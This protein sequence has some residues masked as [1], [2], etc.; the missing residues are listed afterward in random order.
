[1]QLDR[2][3]VKQPGRWEESWIYRPVVHKR[4]NFPLL[5]RMAGYGRW[6]QGESYAR[7]R[8]T[9]FFIEYVQAGNVRLVQENKDYLIEAGEAY[10]LRK[11]V[12]HC[13]STGPAGLVLKRF[14][15]VAGS[16]LDHYLQAL[17][18]WDRDVIRLSNPRAFAQLMKQ[19][20]TTL[21][22]PAPEDDMQTKIHL[23]CLAYQLLLEL[24]LSIQ[25]PLPALI[26]EALVFMNQNLHRSLSRQEI[27]DHLGISMPYFNRLFSYHMHCTPVAYFL[28]QKFNWAAQLLKTTALSVKEISYKTGFDDPLY[29]SGQFKKH[30]G[31]SPSDYRKQEELKAERQR[32]KSYHPC[33]GSF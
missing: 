29:F 17:G 21:A 28:R 14:V 32:R 8:C 7:E 24:S 2:Y 16:G 22:Q 15:Q 12:S 4:Y 33:G 31:S 26:E 23:S 11:G 9:D 25:S 20:T 27:C 3:H 1:M 13:Y 18:L 6:L 10:L 19:V 30:F 5:V